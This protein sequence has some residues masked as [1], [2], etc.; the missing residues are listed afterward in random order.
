VRSET[1]SSRASAAAV[2]GR[3]RHRNACNSARR[4]AERLKAVPPDPTSPIAQRGPDSICQ[5]QAHPKPR[6]VLGSR[7][8]V[9][10]LSDFRF[11]FIPWRGAAAG[12]S[13]RPCHRR[14]L[15]TVEVVVTSAPPD[16]CELAGTWLR[17]NT[18]R[19]Q[20]VHHPVQR[21]RDRRIPPEPARRGV[22]RARSQRGCPQWTCVGQRT[23]NRT[24]HIYRT[25]GRENRYR[26]TKADDY[27]LRA[28]QCEREAKTATDGVS[29]STGANSR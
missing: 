19:R 8:A 14:P 5:Q 1:C 13:H 2:T 28:D 3:R 12:S 7:S 16:F 6:P 27:R 26:M 21:T 17:E 22:A 24:R 20:E 9:C 10:L 4:R 23:D 29:R 15:F 18:R 11:E 25:V